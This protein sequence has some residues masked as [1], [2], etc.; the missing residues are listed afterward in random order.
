MKHYEFRI[1]DK[2][3]CQYLSESCFKILPLDDEEHIVEQW[4]GAKDKKNKKIFEGDIVE[5]SDLEFCC[6]VFYSEEYLSYMCIDGYNDDYF[7]SSCEDL[8][9]VG[10]FLENP[11]LL[12]IEYKSKIG[13]DQ[14]HLDEIMEYMNKISPIGRIV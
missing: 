8:E 3:L 11:E 14:D 5:G 12:N 6:K 13:I 2:R 4:I 9:I 10:N 7:L 1:W